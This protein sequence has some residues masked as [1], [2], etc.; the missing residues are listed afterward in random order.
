[1]I[2]K[3]KKEKVAAAE[4]VYLLK[5]GTIC[6]LPFAAFILRLIMGISEAPVII[7]NAVSVTASAAQHL[8][9]V[10]GVSFLR[11]NLDNNFGVILCRKK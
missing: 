8:L 5:Y 11:L 6:K 3:K 9:D 1:M 7:F 4:S 2:N 10:T